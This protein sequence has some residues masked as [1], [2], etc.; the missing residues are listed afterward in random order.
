MGI[1]WLLIRNGA[2]YH[3][4]QSYGFNGHIVRYNG[5]QW[6]IYT[7]YIYIY[8]YMYMIYIIYV[9]IVINKNGLCNQ[10]SCG[11]MVKRWIDSIPILVKMD[12]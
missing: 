8:I 9:L 1:Q 5:P 3:P 7:V 2:K 4:S 11:S 6:D 12:R 10:Q